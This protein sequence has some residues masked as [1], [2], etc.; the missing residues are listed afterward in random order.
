MN[1]WPELVCPCPHEEGGGGTVRLEHTTIQ[2]AGL[3]HYFID[4]ALLGTSHMH[5]I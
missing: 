5:S 3:G 2:R 1:K 4:Q